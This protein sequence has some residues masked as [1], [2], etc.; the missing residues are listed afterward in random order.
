MKLMPASSAARISAS[1]SSWPS[2]PIL[3]Q[4]PLAAAEGHGA[5]AELRDAEAGAAERAVA[6]GDG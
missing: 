6:H 4:M 5:E 1:A 2:L 3:L